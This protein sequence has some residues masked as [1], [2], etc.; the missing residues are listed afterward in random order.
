MKISSLVQHDVTS[1][2]VHD[3]LDRAAQLMWEHDVGCLPVID[4]EGRVAGMITDRDTCMAAYTRGEPLRA[5][6]VE[7]AM[8]KQVFA[9][10]ETDD[11]DAINHAMSAHQIRRMPVIDDLGHLAGI[12]SL[13]DLARAAKAGRVSPT[14]IASTMVAVAKPRSHELVRTDNV[15]TAL[16]VEAHT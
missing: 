9:C 16:V 15:P 8:A 6:S 2:H 10:H 3:T 7:T 12:V 4:D 5:I 14:E 13:N 1:C 11:V